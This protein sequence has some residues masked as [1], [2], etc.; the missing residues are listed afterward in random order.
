[1][2]GEIRAQ[3]GFSE[4][5]ACRLVGLHRSSARYAAHPARERDMRERLKQL[6]WQRRRFGYR[7]LAVLLRREGWAVNHK[8]VYR[9][10]R[11]EGLTLHRRRPTRRLLGRAQPL[12][13]A[14]RPNQRWSIDFMHDALACGRPFRILTVIDDYTRECP[15]LEVDTSLPA[16]RVIRVLERVTAARGTPEVLVLDNGPECRSRQLAAWAHARGI[17]LRFIEPGKPMQNAYVESFNGKLRDECLNEHWFGS[18]ADARHVLE[19][20]RHDYNDVRPHSALANVSP[21]TFAANI[22]TTGGM[23]T[24][25]AVAI[26]APKPNACVAIQGDGTKFQIDSTNGA[27]QGRGLSQ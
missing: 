16:A 11:A 2:V 18:L 14:T 8:R 17:T 3:F 22:G 26:V 27:V 7:R 9:Q 19:T 4:R 5:R 20:W 25:G 12:V 15:A 6:A 21:A 13:T 23:S 1:V 10:Y 24:L